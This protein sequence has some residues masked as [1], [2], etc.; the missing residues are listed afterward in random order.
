MHKEPLMKH[1]FRQALSAF[2]LLCL[3]SCAGVSQ[4]VP[5]NDESILSQITYDSYDDGQSPKVEE[6]KSQRY[7]LNPQYNLLCNLRA[8]RIAQR[9]TSLSFQS[10]CIY[11]GD[12]WGHIDQAE[13]VNAGPLKL[14]R[15]NQKMFSNGSKAPNGN[16]PQIYQE[17]FLIELN[18]E[19]F[20]QAVRAGTDYK[21]VLKSSHNPYLAIPASIPP[22]FMRAF[23]R[24]VQLYWNDL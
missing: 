2:L 11:K 12:Q 6:L 19:H 14:Y 18:Q 20:Q 16:Q 15:F 7:Q 22:R 21:F 10:N 4:Q 24:Y 9:P 17:E 8:F 23:S 5:D 3:S 1:S 13:D